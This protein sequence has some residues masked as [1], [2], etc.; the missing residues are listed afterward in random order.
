MQYSGKS[1][2]QLMSDFMD[3]IG[4]DRNLLKFIHNTPTEELAKTIMTEGL[5][6]ENHLFY[7]ADQVSGTDP[8]EVKYFRMIRKNY[9]DYTVVIEIGMELI[10]YIAQKIKGYKHCYTEMLSK[11]PPRISPDGGSI[12]R[13]PEQFIKGYFDQKTGI[14]V[15]N[16]AFSPHIFL[17]IFDINI[18]TLTAGGTK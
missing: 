10:E 11:L 2:D 14:K 7:T 15:L 13:L 1:S 6:Y 9:G 8:V 4:S 12:Y 16:P 18:H 17:E 5:D 3:F